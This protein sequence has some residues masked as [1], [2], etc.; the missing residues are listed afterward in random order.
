MLSL[1]P[2]LLKVSMGPRAFDATP[3]VLGE[4]LVFGF[5]IALFYFFE[6][7]SYLAYLIGIFLGALSLITSKF[8]SQV[9]L[10][11]SM[12]I[13]VV[14]NSVAIVLAPF[15]IFMI[16][17]VIS[18]ER[19]MTILIGQYQH[20]KR[21]AKI[22]KNEVEFI[23]SINRWEEYKKFFKYMLSFQIKKAYSIFH[24]KLMYLNYNLL[25]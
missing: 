5:F 24:T 1:S 9:I 20:L 15:F 22:T 25:K 19:Y 18:K 23:A 14:L 7:K 13:G 17:V 16:A 4:L 21:F 6:E 2:T 10:L 12:F 3:R 11:F 8:S